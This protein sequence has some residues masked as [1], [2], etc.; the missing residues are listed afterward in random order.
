MN[1]ILLSILIILLT[2]PAFAGFKFNPHTGK[3][4][5]V[6]I[7]SVDDVDASMCSANEVL[8]K[9]S[10][11]TAWEC[12]SDISGSA[13]ANAGGLNTHVQRNASN[14]LA[15][16]AGFTYDGTSL[17]NIL[18]GLA[19]GINTSLGM[20]SID[21][22]TDEVQHFVQG[23]STQTSNIFVF[24][25]S[26]GTDVLT[27][28]QTGVRSNQPFAVTNLVSCDTIDTD[29]AGVMRCGGDNSSGNTFETMDV[30]AGTDP[31]A[32]TST[33]TL[34]I[35]ETTPL[36]ITGDSSTDTIDIT[37]DAGADFDSAGLI[38]ANAVALGTDT[39]G[40]Y[41]ATI[42]DAGNTT[43]TVVNSGTETA[44]VTLDAVDLNC[45][46][47]IGTTEIADSYVL[48]AGDTMTG[49]L[50]V[51]GSADAVQ[52]TVQ[53]NATQTSN[54]F[55]YERSDGTDILTGANTGIKASQPV[56]ITNLVSCNTID[57]NAQGVLGCG[58]DEGGGGN[59]F[60]TV[61]VP[62]GTDPVA[63][64]S[65]DTLVI[66]ETSPLVI[67]GDSSTDTID[68]TWS[69]VDIGSD[70]TVQAN[71]VALGTDTTNNYV[72][73]IADSG[74]TT[75]T[76]ANSGTENAAVTLNV[77]DLNCTDCIGT[78]E[79]SDSYVLNTGDTM[80]GALTIDGSADANQLVVQGNATQTSHLFVYEK[81]DGTDVFTGTNLGLISAASRGIFGGTDQSLFK[82]GLV[83]NNDA[84]ADIDDDFV[85]KGDTDTAM[86]YGDASADKV[87]IGTA[88]PSEKLSVAGNITTT[89]TFVSTISTTI[90]WSI[91]DQTDNQACNTGCTNGCVFGIE[92][93]TGTA[94]TNLLSC[95]DTTADLCACA[96]AN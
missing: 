82:E 73:T 27:G 19:V 95:A 8:K 59:T 83:V 85:V 38:E 32:D 71:A 26:S 86:I 37:V 64:S 54:L 61:D 3:P 12:S 29:A 5:R 66:T 67:T 75:V 10:A 24:E 90:G 44:A 76:V 1:K 80:T 96:G 15:G 39:T 9:N 6:G 74:N 53:S 11:G 36:V 25:R 77:I 21:G 78:T 62:A 46:D 60:E 13:T 31:V 48:N 79:I 91:V 40:N 18:S 23:H 30:P 69:S 52:L 89:G 57:S 65:T 20:F 93:A 50:T 81:S 70:G 34:V 63:E 17:V 16:N 47:C 51:D 94:V 33:D 35:T 4:D 45:T 41:V 92:N 14:V 58:T 43:I 84:G 68:I 7:T 49:A 55:V 56:A 42:A 88:T 28:S 87:G 22:D 72:A 2:T